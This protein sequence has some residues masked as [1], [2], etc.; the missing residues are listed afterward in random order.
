MR[1]IKRYKAPTGH[2]LKVK[3]HIHEQQD[4][5]NMKQNFQIKIIHIFSMHNYVY[6]TNM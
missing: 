5:F 3:G 6:T 4:G 1:Q 2:V